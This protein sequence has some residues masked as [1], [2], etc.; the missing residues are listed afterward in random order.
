M[1]NENRTVVDVEETLT[2]RYMQTARAGRATSPSQDS[3]RDGN[4]R[5]LGCS[6]YP[7]D[8]RASP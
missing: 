5:R 8:V 3:C 1:S 6:A 4:D 2:G 7:M